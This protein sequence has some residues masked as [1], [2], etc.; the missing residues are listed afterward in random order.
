MK[1]VLQDTYGSPEV[2]RIEGSRPMPATALLFARFGDRRPTNSAGRN[3]APSQS[4]IPRIG[5]TAGGCAE[6]RVRT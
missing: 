4:R 1:T 6:R 2:T 5:K 3:E